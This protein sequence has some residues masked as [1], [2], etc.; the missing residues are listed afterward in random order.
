MVETPEEVSGVGRISG[1]RN[2]AVVKNMEEA[3]RE[4]KCPFCPE[5]F[6]RTNSKS[7]IDLSE[8]GS[9]I[10]SWNVWWNLSPMK[11]TKAHIVLATKYHMNDIDE[12]SSD[13]WLELQ[14]IIQRLK[15]KFGYI[16]YSIVSRLGDMGFNSATVDHLHVHV[17][18][19]G[20]EQASFGD[21]PIEY[22]HAIER[23]LTMLPDHP[24]G[25]LE[26]LNELREHL[27]VWRAVE[28]G[29]ALPIRVKLSNKVGD[30]SVDSD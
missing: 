26:A 17:I 6:H 7:V 13:A 21:I 28:Q 18:V 22:L 9:Q 5:M 14:D 15:R 29:K 25:Q 4:N 23:L 12:L 2:E 27:D 30:N 16:S 3:I 8:Y 1:L 11:G 19:S 20:G 24:E 10:I